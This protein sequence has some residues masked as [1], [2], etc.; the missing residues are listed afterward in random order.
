MVAGLPRGPPPHLPRRRFAELLVGGGL[1][2]AADRA[3]RLGHDRLPVDRHRAQVIHVT[4]S[5]G[6]GPG[7][8]R[9]VVHDVE[10]DL[11]AD[12]AAGGAERSRRRA[13]AALLA[14]SDVVE[15]EGAPV[16][17]LLA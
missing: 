16:A 7:E 4:D 9:Y 11:A 13:F 15:R 1:H 14:D 8:A 2:P 17:D 10:P 6:R 5:E 12:H 3:A